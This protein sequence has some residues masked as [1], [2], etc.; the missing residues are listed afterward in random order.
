[1][2]SRVEGLTKFYGVDIIATEFTQQNQPKFVFRKLDQV[3]VKGKLKGISIY[4][5]ICAQAGLTPEL[6]NELDLHHKAL[7]H[8]FRQ[9]WDDALTLMNQLHQTYPDKKIYSL[10]VD[11]IKEFKEH[12]LPADWDGI[13]VHVT[14]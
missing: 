12:P 3:R 6:K 8:Y 13:Y 1:L 10:Y 14:K 2:G 5:V 11:R 4:Q 9:Q 7:D